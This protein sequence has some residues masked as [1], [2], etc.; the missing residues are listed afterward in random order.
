[1]VGAAQLTRIARRLGTDPELTGR[2]AALEGGDLRA[3]LL[4]VCGRPVA[5]A[6]AGERD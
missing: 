3:P 2:L 1:M 5:R 4:D 6:S